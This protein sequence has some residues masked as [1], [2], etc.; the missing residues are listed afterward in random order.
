M[1]QAAQIVYGGEYGIL[2][3]YGVDTQLLQDNH[4]EPDDEGI[5]T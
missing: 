4:K 3:P 5:R 1:E 2:N